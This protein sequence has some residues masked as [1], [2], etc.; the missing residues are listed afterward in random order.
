MRIGIYADDP[1]QVASLCRELD[2]QF[3]W[4]AGPE[5]EGTFP[6]PVYDD[7]AAAMAD[8]PASMVIDCI[9]DL[10]DQQSMVVPADAVFYLLG[11]GRGFSGSGANSA[12][13]AASAQLSASI[14]KILKKIDLLNIYSQKLTQVGGQLNEASAGILG[15]LERT[16]RILDSI[17]RIAKRSKII[18]LNSAIEAARVGEQG[19]GFA[20]VAEEI[21]TLADDSAQSILDIGKILTGIKQRSDE[22]A[23]RTSSVNDFSDMQQQTTS[24]ISAM[25]QALKELGQHLKQL[26]A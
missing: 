5:L 1:G 11:A 9:G 14:D 16:G 3:L 26:P 4:A 19:R 7:Y 22:F 23:L 18:G 10:R 25:L 20:V 13:L 17:T 8:N 15:D 6:F 21:K 24:E 2:A 12:F